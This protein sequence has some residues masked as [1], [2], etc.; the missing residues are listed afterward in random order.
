MNMK[1]LMA[2]VVASALAVTS[3]ATVGVSAADETKTFNFIGTTGSM[4]ITYSQ[5]VRF[6]N[7]IDREDVFDLDNPEYSFSYDINVSNA[8]GY[9]DDLTKL[10]GYLKGTKTS[11]GTT[12]SVTGTKN[13]K[14]KD[15][16]ATVSAT[17]KVGETS[18]SF[19]VRYEDDDFGALLKSNDLDLSNFDTI[20]TIKLTSTI[21]VN[22]NE[23]YA[24]V[25]VVLI[26]V[27]NTLDLEDTTATDA[28]NAASR[29]SYTSE[30]GE[31]SALKLVADQIYTFEGADGATVKI[32]DNNGSWNDS[33]YG[34]SLGHNLLRWT[35]DNIV[36]N[37]GAKLRI[38]FMT[39]TEYKEGLES[40]GITSYPT[41]D[42]EWSHWQG[43]NVL[44]PEEAS[45]NI[46]VGNDVF[47]GV[48]LQNTTKLQQAANIV[49]YSVEFDWDKLVQNSVSTVSG[50]VDS[51]AFR[52]NGKSQNVQSLGGDIAVKSIEIVVPDQATVAGTPE[53][54]E[55]TLTSNGVSATASVATITGNGG[56]ELIVNGAVTATSVSYEL[57]LLDANGNY[58]QPA[59][60][61]TLKLN[62]PE[63]VTK[64]TSD[65]VKHTCNDGTVEE[66]TIENYATCMSDG[67]VRVKTSK[68]STFEFE[69]E[70][71][72]DQV[73]TEATTTEAPAATTTEAPAADNNT[74]SNPGTGV[75][76]AVIPAIVA[77]AGVVI[78]KKRG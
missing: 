25:G 9:K 78:S 10:S 41:V 57:K 74:N 45:G 73:Q 42:Q 8:S 13:D 33:I 4:T 50:N 23:I 53:S 43:T 46:D 36:Q 19:R 37:R 31:T 56:K 61:V 77:A 72:E 22:T 70:T 2:G 60:E 62:I 5:T 16:S 17:T 35:N 24:P 47:I 66:L 14:E 65:K 44:V 32:L 75:A 11:R 63:K 58:V 59:G 64:V 76:L 12:I 29:S 52:L 48:N 7:A 21:Y 67:Y 18:E 30:K 68:F 20:D 15:Y 28:I 3:L 6:R 38:N 39:P 49:D 55:L 71:E 69:V 40:G 51:I 26:D 34:I 54:T 1:K 27:K